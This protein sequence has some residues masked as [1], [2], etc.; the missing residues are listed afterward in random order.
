MQSPSLIENSVL[1]HFTDSN[2]KNNFFFIIKNYYQGDAILPQVMYK[3][4]KA[5]R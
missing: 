3:K 2:D 1:I 5:F 4:C